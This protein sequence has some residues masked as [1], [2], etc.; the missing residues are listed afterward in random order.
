VSVFPPVDAIERLVQH[1]L[2]YHAFLPTGWIHLPTCDPNT[3]RTE[4]LAAMMAAGACLAP[5]REVQ[6]FGA[7]LGY[8]VKE[9]IGVQVCTPLKPSSTFYMEVHLV[10]LTG[11]SVGQRN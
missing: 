5:V 1:Y 3:V 7:A 9:A 10:I 6:Q 11:C 2:Q 4:L 8:V